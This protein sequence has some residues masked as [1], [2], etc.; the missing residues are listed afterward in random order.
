MLHYIAS[1]FRGSKTRKKKYMKK[2]IK[3]NKT[4]K[5]GGYRY[6]NRVIKSNKSKK[7]SK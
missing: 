6:K 1:I 4:L 3:K 2:Y 5:R 7:S